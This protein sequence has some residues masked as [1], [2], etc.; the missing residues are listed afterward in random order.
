MA[1]QA[2]NAQ[3]A[4]PITRPK[5]DYLPYMLALPIIIYESVFILIPIIQQ[6]GSSFTSDVI[7]LGTVKF[8][9]LANYNRLFHDAKFF[10]SLK[11]TL[12]FM[13]GT[14]VFA[15]GA[16]LLSA[17]IM[18]RNFRGRSVARTIITLPWAFPDL[19]TIIVF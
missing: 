10:N 4:K 1:V 16:G 14:V 6:F 11:V 8:V 2:L 5:R 3:V 13:L 19:P 15:V 9:G 18:N 7:G 17:I 12:L